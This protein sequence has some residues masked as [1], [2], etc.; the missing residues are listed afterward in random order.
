[1]EAEE[2]LLYIH[3]HVYCHLLSVFYWRATDEL[4]TSFC[5]L[6]VLSSAFSSVVQLLD[7]LRQHDHK[8]E[9]LEMNKDMKELKNMLVLEN[10]TA[11]LRA[12]C[13]K[14]E[15]FVH[16]T[17]VELEAI[18]DKLDCSST[19]QPL[20]ISEETPNLAQAALTFA[21][22]SKT[23]TEKV[24]H[25]PWSFYAVAYSPTASTPP[26]MSSSTS[27]STQKVTPL[28]ENNYNTW[29]PKMRANLA[30]RKVWFIVSGEDSRP[31]DDAGAVA[32]RDKAAAAA[33][34]IYR[35]L[36]PGQ[37]VHVVGIEMDPVKMWAK[38]AEVHPQK[39]SGTRFNA[40]DALLAVRKGAV[41][42]EGV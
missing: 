12:G 41:L 18:M 37:R 21:F 1:M 29:M 19:A 3:T 2:V 28:G 24:V 5:S 34:A 11:K 13:L 22:T 25:P 26:P 14:H 40:L 9:I 23:E 33:G 31:S 39:V 16:M 35:A 17:E 15:L 30:E 27:T 32:W 36:E 6:S 38:L 7:A 8:E 4:G 42:S 10:K 20:P